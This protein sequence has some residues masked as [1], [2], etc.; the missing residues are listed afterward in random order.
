VKNAEIHFVV[1]QKHKAVVEA[2]PFIDKV[3]EYNGNMSKL[4][5]RLKKENFDYIIDLHNNF[6]ST[7]IKSSLGKPHQTFRKLNFRKYL[8]TRFKINRLPKTHIVDRYLKT[9]E[10]F[11]VMNDEAGLNFF[12]PAEESYD[13]SLLPRSFSNGYIAFVIGGTYFTKRLPAEK[14]AEI[15][16][17]LA[18]PFILLGGRND[19]GEAEKILSSAKG[20]IISLAGKITL[21]QSASVIKTANVVLTNDTGLMHIAAAFKKKILSFWG[22]TVPDFGMYPY[23]PDLASELIEVNG[24]KCRPCSKIGYHS[25]PK[26]H[27]NCMNKIETDR[28]IEWVKRNF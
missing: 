18:Y 5:E 17:N 14:V 20:Q 1:K 25:C 9:L 6:R 12:I 15:C 27:F 19:A 10:R 21:C 26:H 3:H 4:L 13:F 11:G 7:R 8:L 23:M 28:V 2:N 24:L 22:N 16:N